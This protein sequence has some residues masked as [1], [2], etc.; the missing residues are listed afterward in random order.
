[1]E[2]YLGGQTESPRVHDGG[3][4]DAYKRAES[5]QEPLFVPCA[6]YCDDR[7][8]SL[9]NM[10]TGVMSADG[11]V[12]FSVQY[13]GVVKAWHRHEQQFDFWC[14]LVGHIKAGVFRETDGRKWAIVMGEKRPGVLI[15]PRMLWH[16]AATVGPRE[17][18]LLYYM[19]QSYNAAKPDEQR[20]AWDSVPGFDWQVA[21]R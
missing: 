13:P 6:H 8:W 17:A 4:F 16:G 10:M 1:M 9:M 2:K 14:C 15:I 3:W 20:R 7:G 12:N 19:T 11:Q 5:E 18:G 21:F